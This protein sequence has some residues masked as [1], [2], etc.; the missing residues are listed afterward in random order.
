MIYNQFDVVVIPFPFTDKDSYK[1]RPVL[2]I[3]N[4]TFNQS[5]NQLILSMI[6]TAKNSSWESDI[7]INDYEFANLSI[8]SIIR[9]KLFT[10]DSSLVIRKLGCLSDGDI[11]TVK[12]KLKQHL[13]Q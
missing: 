2:I 1:R 6:T 11:N 8:P 10:L 5:H 7:I 12:I 13:F 3:S 4:Q 9:L